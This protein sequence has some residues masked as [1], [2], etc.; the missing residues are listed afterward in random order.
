MLCVSHMVA[1]VFPGSPAHLSLSIAS[2]HVLPHLPSQ[3]DRQPLSVLHAKLSKS[4]AQSSKDTSMGTHL[5]HPA[6][7]S[8]PS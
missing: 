1:L 8:Q 7:P 6:A 4:I 2:G 3:F 5:L